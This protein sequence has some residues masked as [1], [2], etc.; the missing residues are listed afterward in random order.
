MIKSH[1][2]ETEAEV[3][4]VIKFHIRIHKLNA[5][6]MDPELIRIRKARYMQSLNTTPPQPTPTP[7][8]TTP[9]S[10][11]FSN[12]TYDDISIESY[13]EDSN[14]E[15]DEDLSFEASNEEQDMDV[16]NDDVLSEFKVFVTRYRPQQRH[17][18]GEG[19]EYFV[20]RAYTVHPIFPMMIFLNRLC[21]ALR[22]EVNLVRLWMMKDGGHVKVDVNAVCLFVCL[23][24]VL[25]FVGLMM[26]V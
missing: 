24:L 6:T 22:V 13:E 12:E 19:V 26:L 11:T 4:G 17:L 18:I 21:Q 9:T 16:V 15:Y 23:M 14:I 3:S 1:W 2:T 20:D 5:Q 10:P 25:L 7:S 8:E